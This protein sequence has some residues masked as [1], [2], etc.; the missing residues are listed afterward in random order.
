M[1][2]KWVGEKNVTSR[3]ML[4]AVNEGYEAR[5]P[6]VTFFEISMEKKGLGAETRMCG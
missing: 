6:M 4:A 5:I 3:K 1:I 2:T